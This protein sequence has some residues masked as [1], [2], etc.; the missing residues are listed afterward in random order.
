MCFHSCYQCDNLLIIVQPSAS[1]GRTLAFLCKCMS[2]C[3][4]C[5]KVRIYTLI[6]SPLHC[7]TSNTVS[8]HGF[9]C[10]DTRPIQPVV[11]EIKRGSLKSKNEKHRSPKY[12]SGYIIILR[13]LRRT[14]TAFIRIEVNRSFEKRKILSN[15]S[16]WRQ[17]SIK[18]ELCD[19]KSIIY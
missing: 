18:V 3:N 11:S 8:I 6:K 13:W 12:C 9:Q 10:L 1:N 5:S 14:G 2:R 4:N 19:Y 7:S 17:V 15:L 16:V